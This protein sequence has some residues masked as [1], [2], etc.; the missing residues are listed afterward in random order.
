MTTRHADHPCTPAMNDTKW[1]ELRLAMYAIRP[2]PRWSTLS[3]E[4]CRYGPD[5]EWYCHFRIG[6][7][8][9][10]LHVD[11]AVDGPDQR[12][13]VRAALRRVHV[14]GVET[15]DGFRVFGYV[16][17]GRFVDYL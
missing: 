2:A 8:D 1:E 4:G 3:T 10:I 13:E 17:S 6:G 11:I 16:E 7:Y 14:P 15:T 12:E 9:S 5:G